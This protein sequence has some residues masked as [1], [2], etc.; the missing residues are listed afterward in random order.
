MNKT[1]ITNKVDE[2]LKEKFQQYDTET[3]PDLENNPDSRLT[4]GSSG[5]YGDFCF[6]YVDMR[7]S[8][9]FTDDHRLQTITKIYKIFHHC[10]VECIK[11]FKGK[12]RSFDGDRVLAIFDGKRKVN[13]SIECAM[14]MVGCKYD[15]LQPKIK[16]SYNNDKFSF[17][18][19]ISTGNV[20]VSK[21]EVG[22]DKNNRD[23]IWI[24]D[25]PNLGAKLSDEADSPNSI[26]L[27][28]TT[29]GRI[30]DDNRYTTKNG[31]KVDMWSQDTFKFKNKNIYIY[32][33]GY[34][35]H[36]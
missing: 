17:G 15:I 2:V 7:G 10:M 9:S 34:Y 6:L 25:P 28:P 33:T 29:F 23:L 14:K 11:E 32:K 18:I 19:G 36:L 26:Y 16:T 8:S 21:A 27:C 4:H 13:N 5:F 22:Y 12:V 3:I 35:R 20:M 1:D 24:G 31:I 30:L